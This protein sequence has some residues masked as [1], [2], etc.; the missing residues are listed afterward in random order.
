MAIYSYTSYTLLFLL[1]HQ[2]GLIKCPPLGTK[3]AGPANE[4]SVEA[5]FAAVKRALQVSNSFFSA[6]F[7]GQ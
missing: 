4:P 2:P 7:R 1:V 3:L 5:L 6:S